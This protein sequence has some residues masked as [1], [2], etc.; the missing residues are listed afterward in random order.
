MKLFWDNLID[1]ADLVKLVEKHAK[2]KKE[3][4][5]LLRQLDELLHNTVLDVILVHLEPR[6]HQEFLAM[7]H[8]TPHSETILIY[9]KE[10]AHPQIEEKIKKEIEKLKEKI[11]QELDTG[12]DI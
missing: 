4:Q 7:V 12:I 5:E 10:K 8:A 2:S 6:H 11:L 1:K 3:R 9:L